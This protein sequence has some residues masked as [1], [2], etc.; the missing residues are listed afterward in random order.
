MPNL[1]CDAVFGTRGIPTRRGAVPFEAT[2][3]TGA[4][5][6]STVADAFAETT[7][8]IPLRIGYGVG[9]RGGPVPNLVR[10]VLADQPSV[11]NHVTQG[12]KKR[13]FSPKKWTV[14]GVL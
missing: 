3:P 5:I 8:F 10:V 7:A 4:A 14:R 1:A 13:L 11:V 6:I 12:S 2:T 9:G